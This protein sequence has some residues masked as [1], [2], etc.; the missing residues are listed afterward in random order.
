VNFH[1]I[2]SKTPTRIAIPES[3]LIEPVPVIRKD[4]E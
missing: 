4:E 2:S 3:Y 1:Y